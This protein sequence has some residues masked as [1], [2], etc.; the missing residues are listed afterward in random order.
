M[1]ASSIRS[2]YSGPTFIISRTDPNI[3]FAATVSIKPAPPPGA[4]DS[5]VKSPQAIL[6]CDGIIDKAHLVRVLELAGHEARHPPKLDGTHS[7]RSVDSDLV[8]SCDSH[9]RLLLTLTVRSFTQLAALSPARLEKEDDRL[10]AFTRNEVVL[11][12]SDEA[13]FAMRA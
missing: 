2:L 4:Q 8:L 13:L 11:Q 1:Q 10:P 7:F 12:V 5:S 3:E 9:G 6:F